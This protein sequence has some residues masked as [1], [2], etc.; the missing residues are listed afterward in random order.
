MLPADWV[1]ESYR[2]APR[3]WFDP[4]WLVLG[5]THLGRFA[6]AEWHQAEALRLTR[7]AQ[8]AYVI[9]EVY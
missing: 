5:L 3:S 4:G 2:N 7:A 8:H 9:G 1:N 6:E